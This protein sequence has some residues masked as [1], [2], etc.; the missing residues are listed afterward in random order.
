[1]VSIAG[2]MV[3]RPFSRFR[4]PILQNVGRLEL[5]P[6]QALFGEGI[7]PSRGRREYHSL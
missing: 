4:L 3:L 1:M 5:Y 7:H 2:G 6:K